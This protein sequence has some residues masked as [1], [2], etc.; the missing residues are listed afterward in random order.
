MFHNAVS[1]QFK[2]DMNIL[3]VQDLN[4]FLCSEIFIHYDG[5]LRAS[6]RVLGCVPSYTNYQDPASAIVAGNPLI[7][8]LVVWLPGFLPN[9]LTSSEAQHLGPQQVREGSL[10]PINNGLTDIVFHD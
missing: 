5:Q 8:Y 9:D 2:P 3:Q 4:F 7:S 10:E 6:H 1:K